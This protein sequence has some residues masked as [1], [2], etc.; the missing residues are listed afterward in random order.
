MEAA[1][2][3]RKRGMTIDLRVGESLIFR[4]AVDN[5]EITV[6]VEEKTGQRARLRVQAPD[7]TRVNWPGKKKA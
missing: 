1:T 3:P 7:S 6:T 4:G 2:T 5:I